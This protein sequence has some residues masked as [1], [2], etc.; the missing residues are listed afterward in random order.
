MN[1]N[2]HE[3]LNVITE[4]KKTD[5]YPYHLNSFV[6]TYAKSNYN[7][8]D[9]YLQEIESHLRSQ[10]E[11]VTLANIFPRWTDDN[12]AYWGFLLAITSYLLKIT[13]N[14]DNLTKHEIIEGD[15]MADKAIV[16]EG[17]LTIN[18]HLSTCYLKDFAINLIVLG[19]LTIQG[20]YS[21]ESGN[22]IVLGD[23]KVNGAFD[24]RSDYS[25]N[26][27]GGD[28]QA[29]HY[30]NSSGQFFALGK[31]TSPL[32]YF[33]YNQGECGLNRGFKSL[34]FCESDHMNSF[35]VGDNDAKFIITDEMTGVDWQCNLKDFKTL[36][37][38]FTEDI[39]QSLMP[40]DFDEFKEG[41]FG[42]DVIGWLEEEQEFEV[43]EFM[44]GL[45]EKFRNGN[46]VF[47]DSVLKE[48]YA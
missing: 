22:L 4:I 25:L 12:N 6:S 1:V 11:V 32:M 7:P 48:F 37:S 20:D 42:E 21:F 36:Q 26:I 18:G 38:L 19:D 24:E 9:Q 10:E 35:S 17:N 46:P 39:V 8:V 44:Y 40:V 28:V 27:V 33:S 23:L 3:I 5:N 13:L 41:E 34:V 16:I 2:T 43:N 14:A 47:K 29:Q 45:I 15:F 31:V 30:L